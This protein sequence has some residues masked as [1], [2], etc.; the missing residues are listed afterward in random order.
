VRGPLEEGEAVIVG[1]LQ[2]IVPGQFV[3]IDRTVARQ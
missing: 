1:G 3:R 2:R